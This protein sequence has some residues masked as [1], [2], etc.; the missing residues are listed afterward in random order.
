MKIRAQIGKVLNLDKCIGCHTCSVTC[1]NVWTSRQ[2]VEYAWFNNVE[3][4]P[5]VGYPRKWEDQKVW[6]GGWERKSNGAIAPKMGGK[7]R[8]LAKIFANPDLPEIDDYYEP[9][10]F[11]YDSLQN[12]QSKAMP[13]ARAHSTITG[14]TMEKPE[15]GPNWRKYL[16]ESLKSAVG[17]IISGRRGGYLRPVENTFMM[18]LPRLCEHYL[19][20]PVWLPARPG[21]IQARRTGLSHRPD[22]CRLANVRLGC[23]YKNL[24][25][26]AVGQIGKMYLFV[27]HRGGRSSR[28]ARKLAWGGFVIWAFCF[29]MPTASRKQPP[30]SG[31][32]THRAQCDIFLDVR[33]GDRRA[34]E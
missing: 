32:R 30:S 11:E 28:Y 18:Y 15:W 9:F 10:T 2:G 19:N 27:A 17:I 33:S 5:G 26:L 14:E 1:K 12:S 25:Q 29:T 4:K 31:R 3:T 6:N 7:F 21:D 34:A 8:L 23:P 16:A 20:Q 13:T 24:L 22:K